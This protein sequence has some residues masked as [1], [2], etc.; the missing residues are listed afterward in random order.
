MKT[1][2]VIAA[3]GAF[4]AFG[5]AGCGEKSQVAEY[6]QGKYQ[7]KPDTKPWDSNPATEPYVHSTWTPGDRSSWENALKQRALNQNEYLRTNT[8]G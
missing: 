3:V 8:G 4:A 7:G 2:I 5:L 1:R 6:K